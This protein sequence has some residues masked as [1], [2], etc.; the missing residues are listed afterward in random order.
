MIERSPY[1]SGTHASSLVLLLLRAET[2]RNLIRQRRL[3]AGER[4]HTHEDD[5]DEDEKGYEEHEDEPWGQELVSLQYAI[6]GTG[7]RLNGVEGGA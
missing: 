3:D 4:R 1:T 5:G 7:V 6:L 2:L